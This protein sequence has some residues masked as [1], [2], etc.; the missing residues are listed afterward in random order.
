M[1]VSVWLEHL[2]PRQVVRALRQELG[3]SV[4]ALA[5]ATGMGAP[6]IRDAEWGLYA[7]YPPKI[8]TFFEE[9]GYEPVL[10]NEKLKVY[11]HETRIDFGDEFGD[12]LPH[13][14]SRKDFF[15]TIYKRLEIGQ[16]SFAKCICVQRAELYR[17]EKGLTDVV[18]VNLLEALSTIV[19]FEYA[20]RV[21]RLFED[22]PHDF[23]HSDSSL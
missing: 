23:T 11:R 14:D 17:L 18:S 3:Y 7:S 21:K 4:E 9:F 2:K 13:P 16:H 8:T 20:Y 19:N 12:L 10:L 5:S 6:T 1:S 22:A 15:S